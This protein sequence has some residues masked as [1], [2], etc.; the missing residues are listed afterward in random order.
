MRQSNLFYKTQ[1]ASNVQEMSKN[2]Q[3]LTR[4]GFIHKLM[5][6]AYSYMPLGFRTLNK[7]EN[8]IRQ[9]MQ[10]VN[11]QEV[12]MPVLQPSDVWK[13]TGRWDKIDVLYKI[14]GHA[15]KEYA[16]SP[17]NEEV[18]TP[19]VTNFI[20]S[21]KDLPK[22]VFQIQNKFR[23]EPRSKSGLFRCKEFRMNDLYSFHESQADLDMYYEKVAQM[24]MEFYTDCGIGDKTYF[25]YASGGAFAKYSHE[26]QTL[27]DAGEDTI[28]IIPGTK[29]AINR[30]I[31]G[32]KCALRDI[33]PN[34]TD[35]IEKTFEQKRAV[36][37]GNIFKL[38][39][40]F[41]A[42][43]DA[44]FIDNKGQ[45]KP[46]IMGCYGIGPSRVMGTVA[47]CLSDDRGLVWPAKIAPFEWHL[48]SM[49][50]KD[51]EIAVVDN[52]YQQLLNAQFDVLYD[53]RKDVRG[54]IKFA[55]SDLIG[56][57]NRIIIGKTFFNTGNVEVKDRK[58]GNVT[59]MSVNDLIRL[60]Q[61][62]KL[63]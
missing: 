51:D 58:N 1:K 9:Y 27:T 12:M 17:T 50:V 24:Y 59:Q 14:H 41:T 40:R 28:Y 21:Y 38:G 22:A 44:N 35:G 48:I 54:G 6:G 26:F 20:S 45:S 2:A 15:D 63:R 55:E 37:V 16:L 7:I 52:I 13:Q 10:T 33:I 19:F 25:T 34:Y 43:F 47:E 53:D 11:G 57:P 36:E 62:T 61:Q 30:E 4:A 60:T 39:T 18:V 31:I 49:A 8:L 46:I 3:L 23:D 32:D 29:I 56:I 42:P 5:G